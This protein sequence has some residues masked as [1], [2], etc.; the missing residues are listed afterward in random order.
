MTLRYRAASMTLVLTGWLAC[1]QV[2][3]ATTYIKDKAH[4]FSPTVVREATEEIG[5]LRSQYNLGFVSDTPVRFSEFRK[6]ELRS[7]NGPSLA[8]AR[9]CGMASSLRKAEV[10]AFE[11]LHSVRGWNSSSFGLKYRS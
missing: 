6:L 5:E 2:V 8:V 10:N 1:G 7:K 3:C 4:L 11:R 9:N